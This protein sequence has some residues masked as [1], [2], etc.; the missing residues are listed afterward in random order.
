MSV[1]KEKVLY[2][3]HLS[4]T[5]GS[6]ISNAMD[7]IIVGNNQRLGLLLKVLVIVG[8]GCLCVM[9]PCYR[10][11]LMT[12]CDLGA[13]TKPWEISRKASLTWNKNLFM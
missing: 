5:L 6:D 2:Q 3:V 10:S 1:L 8:E 12:A 13:V 11:M 9:Y 4:R 7:H